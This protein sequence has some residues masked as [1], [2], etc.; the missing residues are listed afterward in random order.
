MIVRAY[1]SEQCAGSVK[2]VKCVRAVRVRVGSKRGGFRGKVCVTALG[3]KEQEKIPPSS[4][5]QLAV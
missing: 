5:R 4:R 1:S 3:D 2:A